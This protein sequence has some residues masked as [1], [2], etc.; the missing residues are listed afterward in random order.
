MPEH[1]AQYITIIQYILKSASCTAMHEHKVA[2]QAKPKQGLEEEDNKYNSKGPRSQHPRSTFSSYL[3]PLQKTRESSH[4]TGN[5]CC[6][7][8]LK[9][10]PTSFYTLPAKKINF[11]A[12][13]CRCKQA[14]P[15]MALAIIHSYQYMFALVE[16][17]R[18]HT[19]C[20]KNTSNLRRQISLPLCLSLPVREKKGKREE[21]RE[22][23]NIYFAALTHKDE[24]AEQKQRR[25]PDYRHACRTREG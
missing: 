21:K 13:A 5:F 16:R 25:H 4:E 11:S 1:Y 2:Q 23:N 6:G 8:L 7:W 20:D 17:R 18:E 3:P 24:I 10:L 14:S 19:C 12:I 15:P 9:M 22:R